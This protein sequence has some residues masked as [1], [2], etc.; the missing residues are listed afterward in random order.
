MN[1]CRVGTAIVH[2]DPD[3]NVFRSLLGVLDEHIEVAVLGEHAGIE[4]FVFEL[5]SRSPAV[6]LDKVAIREFPLRILVEVLHVGMRRRAVDVEVVLL[7]VLAVV[8]FAVG[9]PEQA[10]LQ[11]RIPLIPQSQGKAQSLFFV[12]DAAEAVL[13]PAVRPRARL[14]VREIVPGIAV[15]AVVLAHGSPLALAEIWTPLLPRDARLTGIVQPLLFGD[16]D[17]R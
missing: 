10:L 8:A 11:N 17:D 9:E 5:F 12:A 16:V 6:G 14:I 15:G 7:D 3:Q 4:Q 13:A 1:S 2:R